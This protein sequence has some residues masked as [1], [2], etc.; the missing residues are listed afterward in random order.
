MNISEYQDWLE[1]YDRQ[2]AFHRCSPGHTFIHLVEELG[3]VARL[4]LYEEGYREPADLPALQALLAEELAD[5]A[6]FLFKLAYQYEI[7]LEAALVRNKA[8]AEGR[9]GVEQGRSDTTR[10]LA[11]QER[12]LKRMRGEG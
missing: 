12:N 10:Y 5:A 3:E 11:H 1:A 4:V 9:F 6:T 7:D 8:K 2:R